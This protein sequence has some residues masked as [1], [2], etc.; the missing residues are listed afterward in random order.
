MCQHCT[1]D[2]CIDYWGLLEIARDYWGFT[3][4]TCTCTCFSSSLL[5]NYAEGAGS[6][7]RT[8]AMSAGGSRAHG[9]WSGCTAVPVILLGMH[10][11]MQLVLAVECY[12]TGS[13]SRRQAPLVLLCEATS[14]L[15]ISCR[16]T[17]VCC[18]GNSWYVTT[19]PQKIIWIM[20]EDDCQSCNR[21]VAN[22]G[23]AINRHSP[24]SIAWICPVR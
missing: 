18:S 15:L 19:V 16:C 21:N 11:G 2:V 4:S 23:F 13:F 10:T 1:L 17:S 3:A 5:T 9:E 22:K 12:Y 20:P 14:M 24:R 8:Q 7:N 6:H